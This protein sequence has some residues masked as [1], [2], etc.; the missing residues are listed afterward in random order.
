MEERW[1]TS[2]ASAS[3]RLAS[4]RPTATPRIERSATEPKRGISRELLF[5]VVLLLLGL[6]VGLLLLSR[7]TTQIAVDGSPG[8][9]PLPAGPGIAPGE[10]VVSALVEPGGF[11]PALDRGMHVRLVVS[12]QRT[13]DEAPRMLPGKATVDAVDPAGDLSSAAVV[14]LRTTEETAREVAAADDV[15][16]V[17]IGEDK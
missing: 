17:L 10:F 1:S 6:L 15:R 9:V 11:P 14:T 12:S 7:D 2:E 3:D 5:G 13:I 8:T 4:L 16:L